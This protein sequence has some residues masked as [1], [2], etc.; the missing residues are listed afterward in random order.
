MVLLGDLW[1]R[2]ALLVLLARKEFHVKYRRASF[3][4]LW[5]VAL[6]L[7]Q[8]ALLAVVFSRVAR[9]HVSHY[10]IFILS[11]MV[12]WT[13]FSSVLG[14]GATS[15]VD[16]TDLSS[17]VYF[18]RA[19][20]PL[21]QGAANLYGFAITMA[22]TLCL[23]PILGVPLSA[24]VLLFVPATVL[25]VVFSTSLALVCSALHV[26]F[27][28]IRY[29][30]TAA[31]LLLLYMTPVIYPPSALHGVLRTLLTINPMTGILDLFHSATVGAGAAIATALAVSIVW[32]IALLG[33]ALVLQCRFDRV[34][35]DLL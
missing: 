13:Y 30:V 14:A 10:A 34:F 29:V 21:V 25:L 12:G 18:P 17:R 27:R 5:A 16:N 11:G 7:L 6:P 20:L 24:R 32:T 33:S 19:I 26:Y 9:L 3:G 4:T 35:A 22:I 28:D 23:C 1:R 15:I 2:R 8:S 31:L